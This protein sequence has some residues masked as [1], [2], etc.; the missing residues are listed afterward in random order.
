MTCDCPEW[1]PNIEQVNAPLML[2]AARNPSASFLGYTG[3]H[4]RFCPWCGK[5][6][7]AES[8]L[9]ERPRDQPRQQKG[10][11]GGALEK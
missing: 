10:S 8:V 11:P 1:A 2:A 9:D 5:Q 7:V 3:V 6:L 4:F